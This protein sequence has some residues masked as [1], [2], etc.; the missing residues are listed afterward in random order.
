M[1][2]PKK[3]NYD[4]IT[5]H[6]KYR[7]FQGCNTHWSRICATLWWQDLYNIEFILG[8][9]P[10]ADLLERK[11]ESPVLKISEG[12]SFLNVEFWR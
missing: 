7:K 10:K 4:D 5:H 11:A 6:W 1:R 12:P 2:H 8:V 3:N 9:F